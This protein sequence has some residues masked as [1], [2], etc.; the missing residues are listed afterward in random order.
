[1]RERGG[2]GGGGEL[3]AFVSESFSGTQRVVDCDFPVSL[4]M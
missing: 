1:M 4:W 3:F 2:G